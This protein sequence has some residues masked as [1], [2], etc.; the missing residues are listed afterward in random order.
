ML[1]I[2]SSGLSKNYERNA[3]IRQFLQKRNL[4]AGLRQAAN[5]PPQ[6]SPDACKRT[7]GFF[8]EKMDRAEDSRDTVSLRFHQLL[9]NL[10]ATE[11]TGCLKITSKKARS[12][13]AL[14]LL[15]GR[16]VGAVY[17]SKYM[18]GQYLHE[19]AHKCALRDLAAPGNILGAYELPEELVLA[20]ASLFHGETL[21]T[22]LGQTPEGNFSQVFCL[23]QRSGLPGCIIVSSLN[24]ETVCIVYIAAGKV[25]GIFSA[26]EGWTQDVPESLICSLRSSQGKIH[27][28]FLPASK[29]NNLGFSLT[30][31]GDRHYFS[32][33]PLEDFSP[34]APPER[35]YNGSQ[36]DSGSQQT[37][38]Q[39]NRYARV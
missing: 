38:V 17:G 29:M 18:R 1:R 13:S 30:G 14:L 37:F 23:L 5:L 34:P 11:R 20:A 31:L 2:K 16:V 33:D 7:V 9:V 24:D 28:A 27:A 22:S 26:M 32:A 21:N 25:A 4:E 35:R 3:V 6:P 19:D 8:P 10:E 12:R 15:R 39:S 36:T